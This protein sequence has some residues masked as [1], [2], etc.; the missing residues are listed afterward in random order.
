MKRLL[1]SILF[2]AGC[3]RQEH[4][5][6]TAP[7]AGAGVETVAAPHNDPVMLVCGGQSNMYGVGQVKWFDDDNLVK[8]INMQRQG[9]CYAAARD[10]AHMLGP[11]QVIAVQCA[12]GGSS[13][14]T[15]A[16]GSANY[17]ACVD[18]VLKTRETYKAAYAGFIFYQGESDF[19][20]GLD[21]PVLFTAMVRNF[22]TDI[23]LGSTPIVYAQIGAYCDLPDMHCEQSDKDAWASFRDTQGTAEQPGIRMIMVKD[24]PTTD[25]VHH[26]NTYTEIG[27][28]FAKD[29][30]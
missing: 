10:L 29:L 1:F 26:G 11:R 20:S 13:I 19:K 6:I 2:L 14:K 17:D 21:W 15:W 18:L 22:Q 30:L 3:H 5:Q 23:A 24:L 12:V 28:R 4:E 9:P 27:D 8:A 7:P 25:G 16:K